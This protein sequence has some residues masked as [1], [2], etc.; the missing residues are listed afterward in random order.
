MW[1]TLLMTAGAEAESTAA[2][3]TVA[4]SKA[5][6]LV[7]RIQV[8]P[9]TASPAGGLDA[10]EALL[11]TAVRRGAPDR[12]VSSITDLA[13]QLE[14]QHMRD[15]MGCDTESCLAEIAGVT[16]ADQILF[17][18]L[19]AKGE[20][21]YFQLTL[22]DQRQAQVVAS[23]L[24]HEFGWSDE[25]FSKAIRQAVAEVFGESRVVSPADAPMSGE[26]IAAWTTLS[27]A[28]AAAGV[29]ITFGVLA[30]R[31]E[32]AMQAEY[33][34]TPE[35]QDHK[36]LRDRN[37]LLTEIF[38]PIAGAAAIATVVLFI[39]APDEAEDGTVAATV[40]PWPGGAAAVLSFS[41]R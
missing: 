9:K 3:S 2:E 11:V 40:A 20:T 14:F 27:V 16:G 21:F 34:G 18:R 4:P 19:M 25:D 23:S 12:V 6:V 10:Y 7:G 30:G 38:L 31:E 39:V 15:K 17:P 33:T 29:G 26:E 5:T 36:D 1:A 41:F 32:S 13:A 24:L 8:V 22:I 28:L 37:L 35:W